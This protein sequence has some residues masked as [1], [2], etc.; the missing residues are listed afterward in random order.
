MLD[1]PAI[2]QVI[3]VPMISLDQVPERSAL[4]SARQCQ[5]IR[6]ERSSNGSDRGVW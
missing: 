3:A 2:E 5:L 1:V 6:A 4:E